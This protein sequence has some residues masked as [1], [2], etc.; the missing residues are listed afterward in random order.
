MSY[1]V[2]VIAQHDVQLKNNKCE[3]NPMFFVGH[4]LSLVKH[5]SWAF[6]DG[7]SW[8]DAGVP[9]YHVGVGVPNR[10]CLQAIACL[11]N[12]MMSVIHGLWVTW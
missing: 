12:V 7:N 2:N 6:A 11:L 1:R 8:F 9:C 5:I 3:L 4:P 10:I